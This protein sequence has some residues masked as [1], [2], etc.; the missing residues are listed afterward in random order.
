MELALTSDISDEAIERQAL[1]QNINAQDDQHGTTLL[2]WAARVGDV[3]AVKKLLAL[4]ANPNL[5]D[6]RDETPLWLAV[7]DDKSEI[8]TLLL[9]HGAQ[10]S[11][12]NK[13]KENI[14]LWALECWSSLCLESLLAVADPSELE[15]KDKLG[16]NALHRAI[17]YDFHRA[18][19]LLLKAGADPRVTNAIALTAVD[20][21]EEICSDQDI[22]GELRVVAEKKDIEDTLKASSG[23]QK[24][25]TPRKSKSL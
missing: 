18:I 3:K 5:K 16:R 23:V 9:E 24:S 1:A 13:D 15:L 11:G 4:G 12:L 20:V 19:H 22:I 21:A 6:N 10:V 17:R 14:V 7:L 2:H 25:N 8:L